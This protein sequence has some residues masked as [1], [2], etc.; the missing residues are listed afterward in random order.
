MNGKHNDSSVNVLTPASHLFLR[1]GPDAG[2]AQALD[3]YDILLRTFFK[4]P[5]RPVLSPMVTG[6]PFFSTFFFLSPILFVY[7]AEKVNPRWLQ[8]NLLFLVTPLSTY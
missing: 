6:L 2:R 5:I 3:Y 4:K 7:F 1:R 8:L